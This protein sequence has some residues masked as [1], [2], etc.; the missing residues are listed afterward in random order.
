[1]WHKQVALYVSRLLNICF[2]V[3][4]VALAAVNAASRTDP[5]KWKTAGLA[6]QFAWLQQNTVIV[7][8]LLIV[9][10]ALAQ[11]FLGWVEAPRVW[12][13]VHGILDD[14]R[15]HTFSHLKDQ[16]EYERRVTLFKFVRLRIW[17]CWPMAQWL[18]PVERSGESTRRRVSKFHAPLDQPGKAEG[19][20]GQAFATGR[21]IS[22][23]ALPTVKSGAVQTEN[24]REYS[25]LA[26]PPDIRL[27]K[28]LEAHPVH[29][30]P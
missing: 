25:D 10:I 9:A 23:R 29:P 5:A 30:L 6:S 15:D 20:A 14:F 12:A 17:W 2:L 4:T 26:A 1:M 11:L 27:K 21:V 16:A 28:H 24:L 18:I 22:L 19:V 13:A 3:L 7:V 8:P